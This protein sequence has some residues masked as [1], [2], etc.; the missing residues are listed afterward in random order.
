MKL[1]TIFT[2]LIVISFF[3]ITYINLTA[4]PDGVTGF[5]KKNG[6]DFGCGCH[7]LDP[8]PNTNVR[9]IGPSQVGAGQ[10][11]TF[12]IKISRP[13]FVA[14]G[15]DIATSRGEVL[16]SSLDTT[17]R[18]DTSTAGGFELTHKFPK[19]ASMDT[20]TWTFTY[21]APATVGV[22]DTIFATGNAVFLDSGSSNDFWN[23]ADNKIISVVVGIENNSS[24]IK[25]F[26]LN[27][28]YPNPFNPTTK[29]SFTVLKS[30]VISMSLYDI[31][32]KEIAKLIDNKFYNT[33]EYSLELNANNYAMASGVYFYKLQTSDNSQIRK[34]VLNK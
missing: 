26:T 33:G 15:V 20:V 19:L 31:N 9:I 7:G 5:T 17:L 11:A 4:F 30:D 29:I 34:M 3:A 22:T 21:K 8:T 18:R 27:Q 12:Q 24:V 16:L 25:N 13:S 6:F 14:A 1:K 28:N 32:G 10:S 2:T 23:F